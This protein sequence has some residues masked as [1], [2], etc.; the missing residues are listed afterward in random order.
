MN[1]TD[2]ARGEFVEVDPPRRAVFTWGWEAGGFPIEPGTSTVE[3]VLEPDG[4][5]T[6]LRL[7][8]SGL[9]E[10]EAVRRHREGWETFVPRLADTAG[11]RP[12]AD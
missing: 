10:A 6:L 7:T 2:I 11:E 9:P 12:A 3:I 5:G 8:H 1:G 4:T